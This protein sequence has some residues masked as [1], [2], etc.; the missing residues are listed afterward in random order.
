MSNSHAPTSTHLLKQGAR[1]II[2]KTDNAM[3]RAPEMIGQV[4]EIKAVPQ[5]PNTWFKVKFSNGK[6]FTLRP[7][8][9]RLYRDNDAKDAG[10]A[11]GSGAVAGARAA[12]I[13]RA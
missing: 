5:H 7:S 2:M 4:G 10:G 12:L 8:A 9:L 6:V 11:G 1:V 13:S 3:L